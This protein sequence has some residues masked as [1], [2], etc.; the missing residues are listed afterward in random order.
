M[1]SAS[2]LN[3]ATG[4]LSRDIAEVASAQRLHALD[5][6]R[7]IALLLGVVFHAT[8]S[9]VPEPTRVY[10]IVDNHPSVT[11]AFVYFTIHT[12]RMTTFFLIAG[13]FARMTFH[14]RGIGGFIRDRT[15]RVA[16]PL[17]VGWPIL[18]AASEL[19]I[20]W[21]AT[22]PNGG[23]LPGVTNWPPALPKFPLNHLWFL[24]VLLQCY[25]AMLVLRAGFVG[26]DRSGRLRLRVDQLMRLVI[27]SP[28]APAILAIPI[29]VA[30][31]LDPYWEY[32]IRT[33]DATLITP[34]QAVLAF[35]TAFTFGWLL[36]RQDGLVQ[37]LE[38]RW[39]LN[40]V[41]GA[42]LVT[43]SFFLAFE[44]FQ[45][46][47]WERPAGVW[48]TGATCY[49]LATW[50]LTFATVGMALRFLSGFSALRRY[51]ADSSYWIYLIHLPIVL[52]LQ[53]LVSS[54][55]WPWPV[56]F[57]AI[58][59]IAF[60]I[61]LVSYEKFVRYSFIGVVLNGRRGHRAA[62]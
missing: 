50:V 54:L 51:I 16:L 53:V 36:Q 41:L 34:K 15:Q 13:F 46:P 59:L 8:F 57:V 19:V 1:S 20:S 33:P 17:I 25:V 39:L 24:Y 4:Y 23:P 2:E 56:K 7:G 42:G 12:F 37:L 30:L 60:P 32:G 55:D 61:M 47:P 29:G 11:L 27:R 21:S 5:A 28:F 40:L 26:L 18:F 43:I 9:F 10:Y 58:L 3:D 14:R 22:Y 45:T 31:N 6:V 49:A 62:D 35:G 48:F 38:R 52:A 44:F